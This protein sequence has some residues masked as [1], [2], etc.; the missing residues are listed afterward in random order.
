MPAA[1]DLLQKA[2]QAARH[3]DAWADLSNFLFNP[4]DGLITK[5]YPTRE[6]R[7][8][9]VETEEYRKI[10]RLIADAAQR[11]GLTE[12][13]APKKSGRFLVRLPSSLH[14]ALEQ[15]AEAEGVSLN[16][17]VVAKLAAQLSEVVNKVAV[18]KGSAG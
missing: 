5:A 8:K 6:A 10:R 15:E 4:A 18:E 3:T 2:E 1:S 9:F 17:L 12:D 13:S 11:D 16:Q 7:E 14:L